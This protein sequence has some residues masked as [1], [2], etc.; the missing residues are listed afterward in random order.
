MRLRLTLLL[1]CLS[2]Q[3]MAQ[4]SPQGMWWTEDRGGVI[5]IEPCT[6]GLCGRIVGQVETRDPQGKIPVDSSG[7]PVCGLTILHGEPGSEAGHYSGTITN[8]DDG[9]DWSSEFWVGKDG[10]LRLRGY[11]VL[12]FLGQTQK[13]SPFTGRVAADCSIH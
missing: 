2:S 7:I 3:A 4:T 12:P 13:W 1:A 11:V 6:S 10:Q 5:R 9:K 8:P